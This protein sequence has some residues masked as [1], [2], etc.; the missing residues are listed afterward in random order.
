MT[1]SHDTVTDA[2]GTTGPVHYL[3]TLSLSDAWLDRLRQRHPRVEITQITA[4]KA[5]DVPDEVWRRTRVLHTGA[6]FPDARQ[7]PALQ[8]IQ[9]DTSGAD[10]LKGTPTWDLPVPITS[11]GGISPVPMAEY[12]MMMVLGLAHRLPRAVAVQQSGVWPS[13]SERWNTLMPR[14]LRGATIGVIGYGRIGQEIGRLAR[15]HHMTVLG[16]KR[17][18]AT[19][20][21]AFF[22]AG[23]PDEAEA[24]AEIYTPDQLHEFLGRCDYVIVTCPLTDETRGMIDSEALAALKEGAMFVNVARGGIVDEEALLRAL[25][26]GRVAG[27]ALDVFDEEPLGAD[28]PWWTEPGVLLTPHV[29][30]FAPDYEEQV[31]RLVGENIERHLTGSDL[32]NLVDRGRGY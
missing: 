12:V 1:F 3:S 10:H 8:W 28:S 27:A 15:A 25:R 26:S 24:E 7:A 9:L 21:G 16:L 14:T 22:G 29:A 4:E 19:R 17:G 23:A 31:L 32:L 13:P 18:R 2:A 30:G 5:S 6:V 20:P 11:I